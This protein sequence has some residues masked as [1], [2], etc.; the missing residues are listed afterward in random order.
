MKHVYN[1]LANIIF[2]NLVLFYTI[3]VFWKLCL[4]CSVV[5]LIGSLINK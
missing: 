4:K 3:T 2:M 1:N 5:F